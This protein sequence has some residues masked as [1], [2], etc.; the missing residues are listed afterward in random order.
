MGNH[1][2]ESFQVA[3]QSGKMNYAENKAATSF[4]S[5]VFASGLCPTLGQFAD[6]PAGFTGSAVAGSTL[7]VCVFRQIALHQYDLG[8]TK[9]PG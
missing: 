4:K 9:R 3:A 5:R 1:I 8:G 7:R 2:W 6:H